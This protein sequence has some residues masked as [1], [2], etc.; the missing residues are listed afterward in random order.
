MSASR[1][2][3]NKYEIIVVDDGSPDN[4]GAIAD[5][6]ASRYLNVRVIHQTNR[7]LSG[8]R[9]EGLQHAKGEY[10]WFIDSDDWIESN[11]LYRI[12]SQL[13]GI[14]VLLL[15]YRKVYE[16]VILLLIPLSVSQKNMKQEKNS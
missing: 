16:M 12:V 13:D 1:Y 10:I 5:K 4:S 6:I 2:R 7:G 14:D 9:N 11:C 8:A 3:E 15:Q